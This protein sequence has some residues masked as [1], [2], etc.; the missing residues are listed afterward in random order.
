M[1]HRATCPEMLIHG[2]KAKPGITKC[3]LVLERLILLE[4]QKRIPTIGGCF[5]DLVRCYLLV[6]SAFWA[7]Q[8]RWSHRANAWR[9]GPRPRSFWHAV[10]LP[11]ASSGVGVGNMHNLTSHIMEQDTFLIQKT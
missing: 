9:G 4:T 2:S 6:V 1:A 7:E 5:V 11:P 10:P 8:G 3:R